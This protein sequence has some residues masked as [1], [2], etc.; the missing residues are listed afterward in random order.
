M[1][2]RVKTPPAALAQQFQLATQLCASMHQD[3][4]ALRKVRALR[5]QLKGLQQPGAL[6]A[7]ISALDK[8]AGELEG[9]AAAFGGG[10]EA[11][12]GE[13]LAQLNGELS[14]LLG[15][16]EGADAA[17]TT[18]A[19]A[20]VGAVQRALQTQLTRWR[21]IQTRDVPALNTQLQQANLPA[22]QLD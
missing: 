20:E 8:K 16:L 1:D 22:I 15:V 19:V 14:T 2:P 5:A 13:S 4:E 18:Q 17:P 11:G 10:R 7:A 12:G 9:V 6:A 3:Y 21:E